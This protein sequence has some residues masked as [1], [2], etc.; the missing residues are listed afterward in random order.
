MIADYFRMAIG[1]LSHRRMRSWLTMI[2]IF[3]GIT[4][5]VA[6]ISLGQGLQAA[7]A[8]QFAS[9]GTNK[10]YVSPGSGF[11]SGGATAPKLTER[12]RRTIERVTGVKD[13]L[14][15][16]Y[17]NAK[18]T[19]K[20]QD[21]YGLVMGVTLQDGEEVWKDSW[22]TNLMDGR[23]IQK[24]DNSKAYLTYDYTIDKKVFPH[25]MQLYDNFYINGQQFQV[26]GFQKQVGNSGDDQT[27]YLTAD[28]YQRVFGTDLGDDYKNILIRVQDGANP[29][30][31]AD[32]VKRALRNERGVDEGE[33]DFTLQTSEQL[34]ESFNSI[35]LIVQVVIIGIAA[36]SLVIGGI[37]IMNTMYTAVVERTNEIG[38]MKAI[39]ARNSDVLFIFL[40]ESGMLGL[41]GGMLGVGLGLGITKL[42]EVAGSLYI[43]TPYLRAWWSSGLIGGALL[44]SFLVG[45]VSGV[46]PAWQAS[47]QKPVDSLRY[48]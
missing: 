15:F 10:I 32:D 16:G 9:L 35:F 1:N 8:D 19:F 12:D 29:T 41:V 5:V 33:E 23:L 40:I 34:M 22:G 44:F 28:A 39:G 31:V 46:A 20:D 24:G 25:R 30:K 3:I 37:G 48:E 47:K 2:G 7:I 21:N 38:I 27:V 14:G 42:T 45:A 43:G 17:T 6:I 4:A 11:L 26:V 36:I 18:M 13:T